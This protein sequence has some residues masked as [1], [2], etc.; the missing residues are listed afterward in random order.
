[1]GPVAQRQCA[2]NTILDARKIS[3][4]FPGVKALS[5]VDFQLVQGEVHA[6]A[7]E[8][9]AGKST[10]I[11]ILSGMLK[12]DSGTITF[13]GRTVDPSQLGARKGIAVVP[14]EL[15][16]AP[17]LNVA[18]NI[19]LGIEPR[20]N[21]RFL[22]DKENL[23]ANARR[24][25]AEVG[26]DIDPRVRVSQLSIPC[27]ALLQVA[28]AIAQEFE[29]LI[30]D[31][32]TSFLTEVET[33]QLLSIV[34]K[35]KNK[36]K[37]IIYITHKLDEIFRVAD[38]ITVLRDGEVVSCVTTSD[39]DKQ[40]LISLMA[41]SKTQTAGQATI[42]R[43]VGQVVL[44]VKHLSGKAFSDVSFEL[45][46]G[47]ILGFAGL[48]GAGRT[49]IIRGIVGAD[50]IR[51]GTIEILG[52]E[53]KVSSP[54]IARREGLGLVPEDRKR[55]GIFG[56]LSTGENITLPVLRALSQLGVISKY[57]QR[58]VAMDLMDKFNVRAPSYR[59]K[60]KYLSGGNQQKAILTRWVASRARI[61]ILDEPT[62]GVDVNAKAEIHRL[63]H[64][65]AAEGVGVIVVSSE[66]QELLDLCDRILAIHQGRLV[67]EFATA[68]A[69]Q[70]AIL[71]A[72][73]GLVS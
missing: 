52:I 2:V 31:E 19:F 56:T 42:P 21:N 59:Q 51:S 16:L 23:Y 69:S 53:K 1:M 10:L 64:S 29:V 22:V 26:L 4:G 17:S 34:R 44:R 72:C 55:Q 38:R 15:N 36:G 41:G 47:E 54:V 3:K 7:G 62:R 32:P 27:Q 6:L 14:Q 61:L 25:L 67:Q 13:L 39:I 40:E 30:L 37:A 5:Q 20:K 60:I 49:E 71:R 28:R 24:I 35:L 8:N 57:K 68:S 45:R 18:Q 66:L 70:E 12:A 65:L 43:K 73:M 63:I 48:V 9:G 50:P 33:E 58:E 11:G 46:A